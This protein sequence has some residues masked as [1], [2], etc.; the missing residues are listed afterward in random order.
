MRFH[1]LEVSFETAPDLKSQERNERK[2]PE[3]SLVG[4]QVFCN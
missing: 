2:Y 3:V 4:S 1:L